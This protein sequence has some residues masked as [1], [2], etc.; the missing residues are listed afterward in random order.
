ME[1]RTHA[2]SG[3]AAPATG[4]PAD[5]RG[6]QAFV[7]TRTDLVD[8]VLRRLQMPGAV[9]AALLGEE[10]RGKTAL[11]RTVAHRASRTHHVVRIWASTRASAEP[12]RAIAFLLAELESG[13]TQHPLTIIRGVRALLEEQSGGRP[14]LLAIDNAAQLDAESAMVVSRLVVAGAASLVITAEALRTMNSAFSDLWRDGDLECFDLPR[15]TRQQ[16]RTIAEAVLGAPVSPPAVDLLDRSSEGNARFLSSALEELPHRGLALRGGAWVT[17]SDRILV[18][19]DLRT[20]TRSLLE[21][22]HEREQRIVRTLAFAGSLPTAVVRH[23]AGVPAAQ[24]GDPGIEAPAA[25][26]PGDG[27]VHLDALHPLTVSGTS[28]GT[29]TVS[30]RSPLVAAA[31]REQTTAEETATLYAVLAAAFDPRGLDPLL[32]ADWLL[33]AGLPV[34]TGLSL[35]AAA[36]CAFLGRPERAFF[37]A[38]LHADGTPERLLASAG[39]ALDLGRGDQAAALLA[40]RP[41]STDG[42]PIPLRVALLLLRSRASR[43]TSGLRDAR[44]ALLDDADRLLA[45]AEQHPGTSGGLDQ[46]LLECR[47]HLTIGRAEDAAFAGDYPAVIGLLHGTDRSGW[48]PDQ[49]VLADGLLCEALAVTDQ[50]LAAVGLAHAVQGRL[51]A[52]APGRR[53]RDVTRLRL[54]VARY[55]AGTADSAGDAATAGGPASSAASSAAGPDLVQDFVSGMGAVLLG[56]PDDARELLLPVARQLEVLDPHGLLP[57]ASAALA[58]TD[59]R[60]G[61]S[62]APPGHLPRAETGR[63]ASW[64]AAAVA[65]HLHAVAAGPRHPQPKTAARFRLLAQ[66]AEAQGAFL[67]AMLHR[68]AEVRSGTTRAAAALATAAAR[69]EGVYGSACELYAKAVGASDA[70]L[71]AQAM[72]SAAL[73]GDHGLSRDCAAQA[74]QTAQ[75][76]GARGAL[77]DVQRRARGLFG[78]TSDMELG[79]ALEQLTRREREVAQLVAAGE[80]NRS[81]ALMMGVSTRTVEGHLYQIFSKL[82]L[83]TRSELADL[84][85]PGPR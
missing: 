23:L 3:T 45:G 68:L 25:A 38:S 21:A 50:Q 63:P 67:A 41:E 77:R 59:A 40:D 58:A 28:G 73:A 65:E 27:A 81:I 37:W 47:G 32:H 42:V 20:R 44:G 49:E 64:L 61:V 74:V 4:A 11:L 19:D 33:A 80:N 18:S 84:I 26:L 85:Q 15:L 24:S 14:V 43:L 16:I 69:V 9:G 6:E 75:L 10:G 82:H 70:E 79:V 55:A 36:R 54:A 71:F 66:S 8:A 17:A 60:N 35:A 7:A 57:L 22:L 29:D 5:L 46:Q 12:Y 62:E 56:R 51:D 39:A 53:V 52:S 72:E 76:S 83:R 2:F 13:D 31:I 48:T 34:P 1:S 78:D 30:L